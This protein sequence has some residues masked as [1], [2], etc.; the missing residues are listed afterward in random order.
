[1]TAPVIPPCYE[2]WHIELFNGDSDLW[3]WLH[4]MERG[5]HGHFS[6]ALYRAMAKAD[7][8]NQRRLYEAFSDEFNP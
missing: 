4:A 3:R 2:H 7:G 6:Q 8:S 1:M 5:D